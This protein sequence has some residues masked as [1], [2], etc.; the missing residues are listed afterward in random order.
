VTKTILWIISFVCF[1]FLTSNALGANYYISPAGDDENSGTNPILPWRTI[2]KVNRSNFLPGDVV[3]FRSGSTWTGELVIHNAGV[4][5]NPIVFTAYGTGEKPIIRNPGNYTFSIKIDAD[6][7]VVEKFL[8]KDSHE[9]GVMILR[10]SDH[11][12]IQDCEFTNMGSGVTIAGSYNLITRNEVHD[13][14][15]IV[16]DPAEGNDYGANGFMVTG[17]NNE[18]SYNRGVNLISQSFDYGKDGGFVELYGNV[19]NSYIHHNWAENSDGFFEA[20]GKPGSAKNVRICYNVS[21]N[22]NGSFGGVHIS[23]RFHSDIDNFRVENNTIVDIKDY[24]GSSYAAIWMT[25]SPP[26]GGFIFRNNIVVLGRFSYFSSVSFLRSNNLY[27]FLDSGTK[28]VKGGGSLGSG[29]IEAEPKFVNLPMNDFHLQVQSP[30]INK[31]IE[32]GYTVDY[33]NQHVPMGSAPD[34]GAYEYQEVGA[35]L[36]RPFPPKNLTITDPTN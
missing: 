1:I 31:G 34:M 33:E 14:V 15:M 32:L 8:L 13:M 6:Y 19:D 30:A 24:G 28:L 26:P 35:P 20:G 12:V 16:N 23:D 17:A 18:I 4:Q 29:D 22:N 36:K 27:Y 21:A 5:G 3:S 9:G 25:G 2:T 7:T 11:N 10:G